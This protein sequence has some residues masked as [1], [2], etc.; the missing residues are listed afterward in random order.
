MREIITALLIIMT[1]TAVAFAQEVKYIDAPKFAGQ[2]YLYGQPS[3]EDVD[4]EQWY[5]IQG[6]GQFVRN[7]KVPTLIPYLPSP[8]K[9]NGAA[10]II[11]PGGAFLH[12]T[13]G[14]GGY[15]AAEWFKAQGFAT[16]IK[17]PC[18]DTPCFSYGEEVR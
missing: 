5:E 12:H 10:I 13:F 3:K 9:S 11:A 1:F 8:E 6:R 17:N 2:I 18:T 15:E 16:F 14:S 4:F 7:V